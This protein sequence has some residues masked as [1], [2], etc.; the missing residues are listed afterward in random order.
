M[1]KIKRPH[2][3]RPMLSIRWNRRTCHNQTTKHR[4]SAKL[5]KSSLYYCDGVQGITSLR[6]STMDRWMYS[7]NNSIR[8]ERLQ[9][10]SVALQRSASIYIKHFSNRI[11]YFYSQRQM[12]V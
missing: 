11:L 5:T 3:P 7:V 9:I 4:F 1:E 6:D 12:F 2:F 10:I 8:G